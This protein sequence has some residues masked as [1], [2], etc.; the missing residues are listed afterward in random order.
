MSIKC[1][2]VDDEPLAIEIIENYLQRLD[3]FEIVA[4]CSNALQAFTALETEDID[5]LFLDIQ[6]PQLTGIQFLKSLKN[7]PSVIFTTAYVDYAV[8]GYELDVLDYLVKPISFERFFKAVSKYKRVYKNK[9]RTISPTPPIPTN[10]FIV[11]KENKKNVRIMLSDILYIESIKDYV[12]IHE[13]HRKTIVKTTLTDFFKTLPETQ[14]LRVHRSYVVNNL[15][16]TAHT[17]MDIEIGEIEI[18]IGISYKQ[19]VMEVLLK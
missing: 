16:I 3:E 14:F 13:T 11:V 18:P 17:S 15:K 10:D 8:E 1:L 2:I 9:S 6:M 19:R 7:P 12:R 5:L 4:K